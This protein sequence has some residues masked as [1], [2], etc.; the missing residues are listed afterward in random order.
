[1]QPT[2]EHYGGYLWERGTDG[3][4]RFF[5]QSALRWWVWDPNVPGGPQ[6]PPRMLQPSGFAPQRTGWSK[7]KFLAVIGGSLLLC[8][9]LLAVI[10]AAVGVAPDPAPDGSEGTSR[11]EDAATPE[12]ARATTAPPS[13]TPTAPSPSQPVAYRQSQTKRVASQPIL[14]HTYAD[15]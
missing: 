15:Q 7:G 14:T 9:L 11:A 8:F 2:R 4:I 3:V 1:M 10:A 5:D 13:A 12:S 6:P